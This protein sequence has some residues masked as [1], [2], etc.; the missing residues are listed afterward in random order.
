M[1]NSSP[2]SNNFVVHFPRIM[3]ENV[4][5]KPYSNHPI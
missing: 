2:K 1:R 4:R 3:P 5:A